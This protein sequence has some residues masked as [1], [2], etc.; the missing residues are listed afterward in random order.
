M[1]WFA[2]SLLCLLFHLQATAGDE[3]EPSDPDEASYQNARAEYAELDSAA[4]GTDRS[5]TDRPFFGAS[6]NTRHPRLALRSRLTGWDLAASTSPDNFTFNNRIMVR[7]RG[8]VAG[9]ITERDHDEPRMMDYRSGTLGF[10]FHGDSTRVVLGAMAAHV[11]SGL[12]VGRQ[13]LNWTGAL[14][15]R[16]RETAL[17]PALTTTESGALHGIGFRYVGRVWE[18]LALYTTPRWDA[19]IDS[20]TNSA[21]EISVT[22]LHRTDAE[23]RAAGALKETFRLFRIGGNFGR[24]A[25]VGLTAAKSKFSPRT[26]YRHSSKATDEISFLG[27]DAQSTIGSF[28]VRGEAVLQDEREY[29]GAGALR[30]HNESLT[31]TAAG[32]LYS[33]AFTSWHGTGWSLHSEAS[34]ERGGALV[35]EWAPGSGVHVDGFLAHSVEPLDAA[36]RDFPRWTT[37]EELRW[38]T[39]LSTRFS[40]IG[41]WKQKSTRSTVAEGI[42]MER[43]RDISS[44]LELI[45]SGMTF[46]G[47]WAFAQN[48]SGDRGGLVRIR[49]QSRPARG[50]DCTLGGA[51]HRTNSTSLPLYFYEQQVPNYGFLWSLYGSR[52]SW[53]VRARYHTGRATASLFVLGT[54]TLNE[55]ADR[56]T[57]TAQID[58]VLR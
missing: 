51:F 29:G 2:V 16:E 56:L 13:G 15:F 34:S 22:G 50:L 36:G 57:V 20:A 27:V 3:F 25:R 49:M 46:R 23:L 47:G 21:D 14:S 55:A 19:T 44:D 1:R 35:V 38:R 48:Q 31:M 52:A 5:R 12:I 37:V 32:W 8:V 9:F 7:Q 43:R 41:R 39:P 53:T 11:G 58:Y 45:A 18:I 17:T 33:S 28:G 26:L 6:R 40:W 4:F 24:S 30:F 42:F 10:L 54:G